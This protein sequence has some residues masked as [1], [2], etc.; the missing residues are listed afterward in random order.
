MSKEEH[1]LAV[2][3]K[4][5]WTNGYSEIPA[6][7]GLSDIFGAE[8][9]VIGSREWLEEDEGFLQLIPYCVITSE[10]GN[11]LAYSRTTQTGESR[12]SGKVS[13]GIGGHVNVEGLKQR[14]G[15]IDTL[16]TI[17]NS[18]YRELD[19]EISLPLD[20]DAPFNIQFRGFIYDPSD[21]VGR[22][23]LG[24]LMDCKIAPELENLKHKFS[25]VDKGINILGFFPKEYL[26]NSDEISLEGWSRIALE[27]LK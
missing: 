4:N 8:D 5:V 25:S 14:S 21:A 26:L 6:E 24:L 22:V 16:G 15:V 11:V 17:M 7:L 27:A 23:H 10:N 3:N 1:I 13:I 2:K 20:T 19:E 18:T 12:L 9:L